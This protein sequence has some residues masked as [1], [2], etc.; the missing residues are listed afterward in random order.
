VQGNDGITALMTAAVTGN[1]E[2]VKILAPFEI[3][4]KNIY[5]DTALYYTT[6]E[7]SNKECAEFLSNYPEERKTK[8]LEEVTNKFNLYFPPTPKCACRTAAYSDE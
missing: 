8:E 1:L 5:G 6:H 7:A 2:G 4:L 3:G